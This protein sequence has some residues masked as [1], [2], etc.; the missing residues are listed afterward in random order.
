MK[1]ALQPNKEEQPNLVLEIAK[2]AFPLILLCLVLGGGGLV[3][4]FSSKPKPEKVVEKVTNQVTDNQSKLPPYTLILDGKKATIKFHNNE[5]NMVFE[6]LSEVQIICL[7][8]GGGIGCVLP[9]YKSPVAREFEIQTPRIKTTVKTSG[10]SLT[11]EQMD[12]LM[13]IFGV[14]FALW[15]LN[16]LGIIKW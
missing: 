5:S 10:L 2:K 13:L 1:S 7:S 9:N 16:K 12:S 14:I 15:L 8:G 6:N 11:D 4:V 3:A